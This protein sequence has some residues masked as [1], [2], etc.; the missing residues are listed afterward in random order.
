M[1]LGILGKLTILN[2]ITIIST[3]LIISL[4][5]WYNNR[6]YVFTRLNSRFPTL[7]VFKALQI[8][9]YINYL[10]S[11]V[12]AISSRLLLQSFTRQFLL[13][14]QNPSAQVYNRS[15]DDLVNG[16]QFT[17]SVLSARILVF[18]TRD[19]NQTKWQTI[20]EYVPDSTIAQTFAPKVYDIL[21][22]PPQEGVTDPF[23]FTGEKYVFV[24]TIPL[25]PGSN[26]SFLQVIF[27]A[28]Y[29]I[30]LVQQASN[31]A[32]PSTEYLLLHLYPSK[33]EFRI[34]LPTLYHPQYSN[35]TFQISS[36]SAVQSLA[37]LPP[38][39]AGIP[40]Q[41]SSIFVS[42]YQSG[43]VYDYTNFDQ[44]RTTAGYTRLFYGQGD[45]AILVQAPQKEVIVPLVRLR[46]ILLITSFSTFAIMILLLMPTLYYFSRPIRTLCSVTKAAHEAPINIE[47]LS[48]PE[49]KA[50]FCWCISRDFVHD[51]ITDL[52]ESFVLLAQ[53][54][55]EQ[56]YSMEAKVVA[57]TQEA[58]AA[59]AAKSSF[60]ATMSHEIRSPLQSVIALSDVNMLENQNVSDEIKQT[61]NTIRESGN[62]LLFL[63]SDI[64]DFSKIEAGQ[65]QL[66]ERIFSLGVGLVNQLRIGFRSKADA[67]GLRFDI[68]TDPPELYQYR[69][70]GDKHRLFQILSNLLSN[71][72][73]FTISGS[74]VFRIR[75]HEPDEFEF[76]ITDTGCGI[77]PQVLAKLFQP[78]TQADSSYSRKFGGT[79][80]GLAVSKQLAELMGGKIV[81]DSQEE[82]GSTFTL[83]IPLK[84]LTRITTDKNEVSTTPNSQISVESRVSQISQESQVSTTHSIRNVL[85]ADDNAI[86]RQVLT[87]MLGKCGIRQITLAEDG[88]EALNIARKRIFDVV[89]MDLMMPVLSG[90]DATRQLRELGYEGYIVALTASAGIEERDRALESGVDHVLTKPISLNELKAFLHGIG[91]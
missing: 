34:I 16:A 57:R 36:D 51:E 32:E 52:K 39:T 83:R 74:V 63:I 24:V 79:G 6:S 10:F 38:E 14:F 26:Q 73:K 55:N 45:W 18:N 28:K 66:E 3:I 41:N 89:L 61:L 84:V 62:H 12:Y 69:V 46:N 87:K 40:Y 90:L 8:D 1:R 35:K 72:V 44:E 59:N 22:L 53:S 65:L 17:A 23:T 2:G 82:R 85:V 75:F 29:L 80:L 70:R 47:D 60:L 67:L 30:N 42:D 9:Q 21:P 19:A 56:Y 13:D 48:T 58:V 88:L 31:Q 49:R 43:L 64:L 91:K 7:A 5:S 20:L 86:N 50:T 54:L 33:N 71:A 76:A 11:S 81:V 77:S 4:I 27:D 68:I 37:A 15:L 78:F 25:L